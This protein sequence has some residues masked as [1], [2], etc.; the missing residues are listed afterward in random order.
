[1]RE[2]GTLR[3]KRER[4]RR[5]IFLLP[6]LFTALNMFCGFFALVAAIGGDFKAACFAV[7]GA[8]IMIPILIA[9]QPAIA[10]L[11]SG[12]TNVLSGPLMS[13]RHHRQAKQLSDDLSEEENQRSSPA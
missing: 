2:K 3:F 4:C 1:M 8:A 6:D 7:M 11:P 12:A 10:L 5:G 13:L 9:A